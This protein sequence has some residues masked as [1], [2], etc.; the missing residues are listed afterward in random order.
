VK[1][2]AGGVK[3]VLEIELTDDEKAQLQQ[4]AQA[5]QGLVDDMNRLKQEA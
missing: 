4:S 5:V 1:L 3:Q 2:G